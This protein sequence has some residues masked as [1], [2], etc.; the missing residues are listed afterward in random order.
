[1]VYVIG[2]IPQAAHHCK[3]K[4]VPTAPPVNDPSERGGCAQLRSGSGIV[5]LAVC[6]V[7]GA[8]ANESAP[9][10]VV[11]V[12]WALTGPSLV[13][14]THTHTKFS[15]GSLTPTEIVRAATLN[16]CSAVAITDHGD[17]SARTATPE[18]FE[19]IDAARAAYSHMIVLAGMEWNVPPYGGRE[20][21]TV[22]V[23]TSYEKAL[24][25][26]FKASF[27]RNDISATDAL[28]WLTSQI[29]SSNNA[30]LIYNHPSRRDT[31][32]DENVRDVK[33]WRTSNELFVAFEGAPGHQR[34]SSPG[35]Y[36]GPLRTESRWDPAVATIGG[37]WDQLLSEG[38]NFWGALAVS[39]YHSERIDFAPCSFARTH[40]RVPQRDQ[41]GVLL[42]LRAGS[43]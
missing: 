39:D 43:F 28:K 5:L 20:H 37:A 29:H 3:R 16:G 2:G 33:T 27:E 17:R 35:D 23:D 30:V 32:A 9:S 22:L 31:N 34:S 40:L 24:L 42:A 13:L 26:Q 6:A 18:Y 10:F 4:R 14:D 8:C 41:S 25:P 11:S 15:D 19:A 7:M 12:P 36:S 21:V 38:I 1:M